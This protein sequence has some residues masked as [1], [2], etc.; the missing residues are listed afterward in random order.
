MADLPGGPALPVPAAAPG[1]A[2]EAML[3]NATPAT[4]EVR[5]RSTPAALDRSDVSALRSTD[6]PPGVRAPVTGL[7]TEV[8]RIGRGMV[9]DRDRPTV[10]GRPIARGVPAR[11]ARTPFA[12]PID[13]TH[14]RAGAGQTT[15]P[16]TTDPGMATDRST[17]TG[18]RTGIDLSVATG[19]R[20]EIDRSTATDRR[21][22][23]VRSTEAALQPA[24]GARRP[25]RGRGTGAGPRDH[26][27]GVS[28]GAPRDRIGPAAAR[29]TRVNVAAGRRP[30]IDRGTLSRPS[31]DP[32]R[33]PS[34]RSVP[35][36]RSW[37]VAVPSRRRS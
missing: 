10:P 15:G 17:G 2:R 3:L 22:K 37:P 29:H 33:P 35:T 6:L 13:A 20:T 14:R 1:S 21:T 30:A 5:G 34:S 18:R 36:R 27:T 31:G 23:T 9:S 28:R 32:S 24:L 8:R 4:A 25:A 26:R 7:R 12:P 11:P 16:R 19:H